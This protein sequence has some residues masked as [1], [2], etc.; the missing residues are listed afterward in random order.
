M[1]SLRMA[2]TPQRPLHLIQAATVCLMRVH[3]TP[4][5]AQSTT[6]LIDAQQLACCSI[7]NSTLARDDAHPLA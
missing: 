3:E 4:Q 1:C 2:V 6:L 5:G 7:Y